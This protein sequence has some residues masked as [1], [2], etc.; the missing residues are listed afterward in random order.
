MG[1]SNVLNIQLFLEELKKEGSFIFGWSSS[2]QKSKSLKEAEAYVDWEKYV[3]QSLTVNDVKALYKNIEN[4]WSQWNE[5]Y[6]PLRYDHEEDFD[7]LATG[8]AIDLK[9]SKKKDGRIKFF[10]FGNLHFQ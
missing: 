5:A 7:F 2:E 6:L 3:P 9:I 4:Y 1:P 10:F 8:L